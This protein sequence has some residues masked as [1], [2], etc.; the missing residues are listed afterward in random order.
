[1]FGYKCTKVNYLIIVPYQVNSIEEWDIDKHMVL[2]LAQQN[3]H[4]YWRLH[5]AICTFYLAANTI[6][7][8]GDSVTRK[9][10]HEGM[11]NKFIMFRMKSWNVYVTV[12]VDNL[13]I[14]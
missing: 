13:V 10:A 8:T 7:V 4:V 12:N 5:W 2:L 6:T 9:I 3:K 14:L 11:S 1:M